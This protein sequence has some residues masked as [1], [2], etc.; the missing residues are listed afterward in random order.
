LHE[1]SLKLFM[2]FTLVGLGHLATREGLAEQGLRLA[3]AATA[4]RATL[5]SPLSPAEQHEL[6]QWLVPA[7]QALGTERS[8]QA[9]AE[10]AAMT[11]DQAVNYALKEVP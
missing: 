6:D 9:W 8:A 4:L 1:L 7:R 10:G 11:L 3:A 2:A 5:G